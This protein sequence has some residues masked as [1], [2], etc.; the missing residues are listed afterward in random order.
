MARHLGLR[1]I[2]E[3]PQQEER[4]L[5]PDLHG[6]PPHLIRQLAEA[7]VTLDYRRILEVIARVSECDETIAQKLSYFANRHNYTPIWVATQAYKKD[8]R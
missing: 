6:L 5:M 7:L 1:R 8:S 3:K 4:L 2:Y